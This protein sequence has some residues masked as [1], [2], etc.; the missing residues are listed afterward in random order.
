MNSDSQQLRILSVFKNQFIIFLDELIA[1][2]PQEP[3]LVIL[4][5]FM[6]DQVPIHD[7]MCHVIKEILP[8]KEKINRKDESFF[9]ENEVLFREMSSEHVLHFKRLWTSQ[10]LDKDDREA[11]WQ[12]FSSFILLSERYQGA[13]GNRQI[14]RNANGSYTLKI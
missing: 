6:K 7:V 9:L 11:I 2:F 4:R 13:L 14:A 10:N 3:D 1:Q 12:W 5:I 8:H